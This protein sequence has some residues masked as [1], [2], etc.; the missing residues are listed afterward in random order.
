MQLHAIFKA[1][2]VHNDVAMHGFG[3]GMRCNYTFKFRKT[4]CSHC[5]CKLV[6]RFGTYLISTITGQLE[7]I[8]FALIKFFAFAVQICGLTK[9]LSVILVVI[10]ILAAHNFSFIFVHNIRDC[11]SWR[12][13][14]AFSLK[15]RHLFHLQYLPVRYP[16]FVHHTLR[17]FTER[18]SLVELLRYL[19]QIVSLSFQFCENL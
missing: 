18:R 13:F 16:T 3:I 6:M 14:A 11:F 10:E 8:I 15:Q 17:C 2:R 9:L 4:T 7:V 19:V 5:F 1:D 12:T